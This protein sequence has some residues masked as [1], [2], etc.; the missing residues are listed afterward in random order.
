MS[1]QIEDCGGAP[2]QPQ[3][4]ND[5][6]ELDQASPATSNL[7]SKFETSQRL[8]SAAVMHCHAVLQHA[9]S[10]QLRSLL[11]KLQIE[12]LQLLSAAG[13]SPEQRSR[14]EWAAAVLL[15]PNWQSFAV[16]S[17]DDEEP[18][19]ARRHM[20]SA[21]TSIDFY[22]FSVPSDRSSKNFKQVKRLQMQRGKWQ[23]WLSCH[24]VQ[25]IP[26]SYMSPTCQV[27]LNA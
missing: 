14:Q 16:H 18:P 27:S 22:G 13:D 5:Q 6:A 3:Q 20:A 2:E 11:E 21:T 7:F 17:A 4:Q 15:G 25:Q 1:L 23:S 19:D 12:A 9:P 24:R 8:Q 10:H 26:C